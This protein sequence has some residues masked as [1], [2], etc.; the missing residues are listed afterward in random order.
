MKAIPERSEA[1][2]QQKIIDLCTELRFKVFHSGD[3]RRDTG[4]GFPDLVIATTHGKLIFAE[5]KSYTGDMSPHQSSWKWALKA[6]GA[7][8][9][10]WRPHDWPAIE[11]ELR[12]IT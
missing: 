11:S 1:E 3:A 12:M 5:L 10:L 7:D 9:R 8:W 2:L 6:S 4:R